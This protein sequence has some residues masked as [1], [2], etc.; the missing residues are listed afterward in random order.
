MCDV[1]TLGELLIDFA[2]MS[3]DNDGYPT[4]VAHPGGAPA[5]FLAT[6]NKCGYKTSMIGK[7]GNDTF[8]K[9]LIKTLKKYIYNQK[10]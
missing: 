6:L 7:V 2:C 3:V 4:M 5:N 10:V 8:G 9:L 1:L